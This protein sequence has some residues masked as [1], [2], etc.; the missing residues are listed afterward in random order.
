[1]SQWTQLEQDGD[2]QPPLR[3]NTAELF[4][5]SFKFENL[6]DND[7]S[8]KILSNLKIAQTNLNNN[9]DNRKLL[10]Y[11][12]KVH[13]ESASKL[14]AKYPQFWVDPATTV[15]ESDEDGSTD[16]LASQQSVAQKDTTHVDDE[17]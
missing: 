5:K 8:Q 6:A 15:Q 13:K 7:Y 2:T 14:S 10:G 4:A 3:V 17:E 12:E 1:M 9:P 11:F 16:I